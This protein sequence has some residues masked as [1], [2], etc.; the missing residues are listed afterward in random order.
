M[1]A[2]EQEV[3]GRDY[4]ARKAVEMEEATGQGPKSSLKMLTVVSY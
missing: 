2:V 3:R 1:L 4:D